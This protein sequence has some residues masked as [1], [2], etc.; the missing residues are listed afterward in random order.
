MPSP[1]LAREV[2]MR[3]SL[4][5]VCAAFCV[6]T[7]LWAITTNSQLLGRQTAPAFPA[8]S[9]SQKV[10]LQCTPGGGVAGTVK[11]TNKSMEA[12][13]AN[14]VIYL[15][16]FGGETTTQLAELIPAGASKQIPGPPGAFKVCQAWFYK[17]LGN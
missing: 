4:F 15:A 8:D 10:V 11:I 3:S 1:R 17:Q 13:P 14:T 6:G 2:M 9:D 12:I 16:N 7:L 5:F